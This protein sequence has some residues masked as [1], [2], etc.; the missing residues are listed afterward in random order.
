[1]KEY[2]KDVYPSPATAY[3]V[4]VDVAIICIT[5]VGITT[6]ILGYVIGVATP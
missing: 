6:F 4:D 3:N 5:V 1:M 2:P